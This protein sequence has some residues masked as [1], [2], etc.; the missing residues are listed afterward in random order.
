MEDVTSSRTTAPTLST[1]GELRASGHE[2][3]PLRTPL[4]NGDVVEVL[5]GAK[6]QI[7]PDWRALTV[8]GRARSAIKRQFRA[9]E[10]EGFIRLGKSSI[11]EAFQRAGKDL[12]AV[13]LRPA[14]DRYAAGGGED[15]LYEAV[16]RGRVSSAQPETF[17]CGMLD[18]WPVRT[19]R[20]AEIS[21]MMRAGSS[22]SA[23]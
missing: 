20:N 5:R 6:P 18:T 2:L 16:G 17:E 14:Q 10:K 23:R 9:T 21:S 13:T 8:T 11:E 3:K 4:S 12:G 7:P 22:T 19:P 15:E 1:L